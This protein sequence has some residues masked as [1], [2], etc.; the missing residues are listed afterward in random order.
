MPLWLP[1][2]GCLHSC[3]IT[4]HIKDS[5]TVSSNLE[6]GK[7]YFV[8]STIKCIRTFILAKSYRSLGSPWLLIA[9]ILPLCA[10]ALTFYRR[11]ATLGMVED[12][13][14]PSNTQTQLHF[15]R[16]KWYFPNPPAVRWK[17]FTLWDNR[18]R[19][20]P[21]SEQLNHHL[22]TNILCVLHPQGKGL[23]TTHPRACGA[24]RNSEGLS[25]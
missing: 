9:A 6:E 25:G 14:A 15:V 13:R 4:F 20:R 7:K 16:V 18:N 17:L 8:S 1:Y 2:P 24:W 22:K 11:W 21:I 19:K 5:S 23:K 12:L 10:P 3:Y